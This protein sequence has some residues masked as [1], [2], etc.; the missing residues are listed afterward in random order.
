MRHWSRW[1]KVPQMTAFL[2][3]QD[4]PPAC[5]RFCSRAWL[6]YSWGLCRRLVQRSVGHSRQMREAAPCLLP[7]PPS[8]L[9]RPLCHDP[10][11]ASPAQDRQA[12]AEPELQLH[13]RNPV[14][15]LC[16]AK[17]PSPSPTPSQRRPLKLFA[18]DLVVSAPALTRLSTDRAE[19]TLHLVHPAANAPTASASAAFPPVA[20][21]GGNLEDSNISS[22][23]SEVDDKDANDE[24]I[25]HMH[26]DRD[27]L[28]IGPE[29]TRGTDNGGSD[30]DSA[31]SDA[32]S[33]VNSEANDTEAE[34]LRLYDTPQI[35][36]HRDVGI[37]RF[38]DGEPFEHT[39]SKLRRA[40]V[41]GDD[42]SVSG[43]D[44]HVDEDEDDDDDNDD[45]ESPTKA[46][47]AIV[48]ADE[49]G[50]RDSQER[51]R[52]RSAVTEQSDPEQPVRK[53]TGSISAANGDG[54]DRLA[55]AED[56][57]TPA[58]NLPSG[59][60]S[61]GDDDEA[62]ATNQD[63]PTEHEAPEVTR[64]TKR[65]GSKR[66]NVIA[67]DGDS[68]TRAELRDE[69]QDAA[70]E[71]EPEPDQPEEEEAEPEADE[72]T[73]AAARN[74]EE[75]EKK[76]AAYRDWTQIEEM[77]GIFRDRLY[78][79]RLQRLE[80]EEQSLH[81]PE[82]TH[83]EYLNMKQCLD[84]RLDRKLQAINTEHEYRLKALERRAV[85]Q[86]AQIWGQYFQAVREKREQALEG[87]NRQWYDVQSAR[88]S[89]HSLPDYGLLFPKDPS[90]R[91]RNAIAYN[92]EVSTLAGLAKYEGFPAGPEL[93]GASTS[94]LEADLAVMERT[95]RMRQKP[96]ISHIREEY[97]P[98]HLTRLDPAG[99]QFVKNTPWANPNHS[100]HK[101]Y[102]HNPAP[103]EA[104][105]EPAAPASRP[106]QNALPPST[107]LKAA[108]DGSASA[109]SPALS[110]RLSESPEI[111]RNILNPSSHPM[112]Q[113]GS[114]SG[115]SRGSKTAAT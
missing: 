102:Q 46:V 109:R 92:T 4:S 68:E 36:R 47:A 66:K 54:D 98:P 87:L 114:I 51:K 21:G 5:P 25:E 83:P 58:A 38:N 104:R 111:T 45:N 40:L 27:N 31:L 107:D 63:T 67:D 77:F 15:P 76:Q 44:S 94:E 99:E 32:A 39:P 56:D 26:L 3:R 90:Q 91:V 50:Q 33:D 60:Q 72:E 22:P 110:A 30:S 62:S 53:R 8:P 100:A 9:L 74:L 23:L 93:Q 75:L 29:E 13:Q 84:D 43:D 52:K 24:D 101:F 82:P 89:A 55:A 97:Q 113:M 59:V 88:R 81:A 41:N 70:M 35:Q 18:S 19:T 7:S 2:P 1:P 14:T 49:D 28:S 71:E 103:V 86:R 95:R 42:D 12:A 96:S 48:K 112:K 61:P 11:K 79:D 17:A 37:E 80:E 78:K 64:K 85:A 57:A 16:P 73:D 115:L 6:A 20:T 105:P 106:P 65:S 108:F 34:T 69:L 10:V